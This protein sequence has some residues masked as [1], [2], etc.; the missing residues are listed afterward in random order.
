ML[1]Y[2]IEGLGA[3][4]RLQVEDW[5]YDTIPE[6][7]DG[8]NI[9]G[10]R[11]LRCNGLR[12]VATGCAVLQRAALCCNGLRCVATVCAALQRADPQ[13]LSTRTSSRGSTSSSARRRSAKRMTT[14]WRHAALSEQRRLSMSATG[15]GRAM[16]GRRTARA[17]HGGSR[18]HAAVPAAAG[19]GRDVRRGGRAAR[20]GDQGQEVAAH[21]QAPRGQNIEPHT[22]DCTWAEIPLV[23]RALKLRCPLIYD[24]SYP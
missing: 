9:A 4:V 15:R 22:P 10:G 16:H 12:C 5:K 7:I 18:L 8:K 23:S 3:V 21:P 14:E 17:R 19:G 1:Y 13:T 24:A 6:I 2:G 20:G 11:S